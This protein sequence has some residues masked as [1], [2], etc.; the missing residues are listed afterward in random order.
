MCGGKYNTNLRIEKASDTFEMSSNSAN[1]YY[2]CQGTAQK[3]KFYSR[4]FKK[5]DYALINMHQEL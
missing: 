3:R 1:E 5:K 2:F 4:I